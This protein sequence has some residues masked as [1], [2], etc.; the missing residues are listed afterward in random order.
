MTKTYS[1]VLG[2][3]LDE[4]TQPLAIPPGRVINC[5]NHEAV[6]SGYGRSD[7]FERFDGRVGPTDFP[8]Y[9]LSF[10]DG[11]AALVAGN[12]I[13]GAT[14][15]AVGV[16]LVDA[17]LESGAWD[18]TGAGVVGVRMV[19]GEFT[20]SETLTVAAVP[21]ATASGVVEGTL[22]SGDAYEDSVALASRDYVRALI[23]AV[24][25]SGPV[26]G[27]WELEDVVYAFRD[28]VGGTA[29]AMY[30]SSA[31]GWQ[32]VALGHTLDFTSGGTT[33][34]VEGDTITGATSGAT[35]SVKRVIV[36]SG[37]WAAGDVV[38]Y[39]VL[40]SIVG[41]F[42]GEDLDV[43]ASTNLATIAGAPVATSLP[44][45]GRYF[46]HTHN[47]YG[48]SG[49]RRVYG[50]NGVGN[51]FEFDDS[52]FAPIR[53]GMANDTPSRV[54]VFRNHLFFAFPGGSVQ[55]SGTAEPM[56]WEALTGAAEI[57]IGSE[58]ADFIVMT[59]ALLIL[60][61]HGIFSLIGYDATDFQLGPI[62]LE[63]GAKPFSAQR[64]GPGIYLDNRGL[65]SISATQ[66][67]GNFAMGTFTQA[68]Q[69]TLRRKRQAGAQPVASTIIRGKNHYRLFYSD[70]SGISFYLGRKFPE[71]MY[72]ELGKVVHSCCTSETE[73]G[74]E[75]SFFGA[76]DG[77]V[78]EMDKGD[79]F[80]GEPIEAF[81]Q[82]PYAHC[83]SPDVMK[84]VP[85][86]SLDVAPRGE[87]SLGVS[88]E[89]DYSG[90]EQTGTSGATVSAHGA[91]GLW[92]VANWGEFAWGAPVENV[93]EVDTDGAGFN[94]SIIVYSNSAVHAGYDL[95]GGKIF[96]LDRGA[97]R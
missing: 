26:R 73:D 87:T 82:L 35:A 58:V 83:G 41:T 84:R 16:A 45:G 28:N 34:I 67:F 75:R 86:V 90:G 94:A 46:F 59:D 66:A 29:G 81:L 31:S 7:G 22:Y 13:T 63:A 50:C 47:F 39:L 37:D 56:S 42:T 52:M 69:K 21:R 48:G 25:G 72:F 91:G 60:G 62:T 79:S 38:G 40:G 8:F 6:D 77:F 68:V 93:L 17:E 85:K 27:V 88:L 43:G 51:G 33:E 12:T 11:S 78:Y 95:R 4:V 57:G 74:T 80:D 30:K 36:Q 97:R 44:A 76:E 32:A 96:Y 55:N 3:G 14:S 64:F 15:G 10:E 92:G 53:T 1:F 19:S 49:T 9:L 54:A 70:G 65:R 23:A 24:P 71:P 61:E 20:A 89:F 18:G 2:G 5:L